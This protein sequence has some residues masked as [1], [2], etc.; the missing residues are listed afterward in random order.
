MSVPIL[1]TILILAAWIKFNNQTATAIAMTVILAGGLGFY[2][3]IHS[4][5]TPHIFHIKPLT[6]AKVCMYTFLPSRKVSRTR[7]D[8]TELE[9]AMS[10]CQHSVGMPRLVYSHARLLYGTGSI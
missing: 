2:G 8:W 6:I 7:D 3:Y 9:D 10:M 4:L 5:W 1:M